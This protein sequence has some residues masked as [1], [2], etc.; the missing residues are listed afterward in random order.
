M[1][2]DQAW[3]LAKWHLYQEM[4]RQA[5]DAWVRDTRLIS[6]EMGR[7]CV[8]AKSEFARD[9]LAARLTSTVRRMLT[10]MMNRAVEIE[11]VLRKEDEQ[12]KTKTQA[13]EL[14]PD[15]F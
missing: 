14:Q 3:E 2:A 6:Y 5:F 10:G 12:G 15:L 7:F 1:N 9:W 13:E 4:P 11:F 8:E